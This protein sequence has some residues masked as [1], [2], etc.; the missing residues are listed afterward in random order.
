MEN[1]ESKLDRLEQDGF[2]LIE[3]AL[4]PE[5]TE[6]IRQRI[7]YARKMGWEEGLNAV[8]NMWFDTLLDRETRDIC[9]IGRTSQYPPLPRRD[10]GEAVSTT[11][12][13]CTHQPGAIPSRVAHGFLRLLAG[14][15]RGGQV[16][17][18]GVSH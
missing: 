3:G 10:D 6:R 13:A 16:S 12:F 2:I 7:N 9:P 4:S 8:G 5:E 17:L 15:T 18:C 14:E 11:K 1:I